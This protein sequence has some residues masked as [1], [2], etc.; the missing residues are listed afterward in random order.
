MTQRKLK[1]KD[2]KLDRKKT[3]GNTY[4]CNISEEETQQAKKTKGS[5]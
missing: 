5:T 3:D 4:C 1:M 2:N